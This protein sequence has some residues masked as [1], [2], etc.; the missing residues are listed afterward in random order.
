MRGWVKCSDGRLYHPFVAGIANEAWEGRK[1]L[2]DRTEKARRTRLLQRQLQNQSQNKN[3]SV[4]DRVTESTGIGTVTGRGTGKEI[5]KQQAKDASSTAA[6]PPQAPPP[7][8]PDNP[9]GQGQN[10]LGA[11]LRELGV[12]MVDADPRI[13]AWQARGLTATIASQAAAT[14]RTR[15]GRGTGP[16][17]VNLIALIID[18]LLESAAG[19]DENRADPRCT[20]LLAD[21]TRCPNDAIFYPGRSRK[22]VCREHHE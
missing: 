22:G 8:A 15:K 2:R 19:T 14:A 18:D 12:G 5:Q 4:T 10:P 21:E 7:L 13:A 17:P 11:Q 3:P 20:E 1:A 16:I 6:S 9:E